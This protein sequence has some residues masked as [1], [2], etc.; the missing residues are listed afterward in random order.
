MAWSLGDVARLS[1]VAWHR[2]PRC[3]RK[4][5][6]VTF[7]EAEAHR[8]DVLRNKGD[9]G[10]PLEVYWCRACDVWHVGR[11]RDAPERVKE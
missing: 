2:A 8:L 5:R 1:N 3:A 10:E 9:D 11:S 7:D 4:L 6:H